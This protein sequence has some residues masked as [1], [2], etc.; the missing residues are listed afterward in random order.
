[1]KKLLSLVL[2]VIM[3]LSIMPM[4]YAER[5]T[6]SPEIEEYIEDYIKAYA[7][8][9]SHYKAPKDKEEVAKIIAEATDGKKEIY[10]NYENLINIEADGRLEELTNYHESLKKGIYEVEKRI[11]EGEFVI[12]TDLYEICK[13]DILFDCYYS[14]EHLDEV[15]DRAENYNS[16]LF[17][18][19]MAEAEIGMDEIF[20]AIG[21]GGGHAIPQAE[22]DAG[23]AKMKPFYDLLF[24]CLDGNH[25]YGEY[26]SDNNATVE[27]DGTKTATCEFCG[28]TD[29]ITD[30]GT[31]LP[32][33][34]ATF[35][36][37]LFDL[38]KD[39]LDIIFSIFE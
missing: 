25:P 33:K 35:F 5:A 10:P 8:A 1:M 20:D 37:K 2:A 24:A 3:L 26:I 7:Y 29:T 16:E 38:I 12:V 9:V 34:E 32:K 14:E 21:F 4:A 28:A 19:A 22:F 23:M 36:E 30:E 17:I 18:N 13:Y 6:Y 31:K 11:A 27:A 39:F 15:T